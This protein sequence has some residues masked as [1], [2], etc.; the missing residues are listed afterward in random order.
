MQQGNYHIILI[1]ALIITL[2]GFITGNFFF[3]L[4]L[5]PVGISLFK[6]DNKN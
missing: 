3:L 1:I 2:I 4:L 5:V 6:K